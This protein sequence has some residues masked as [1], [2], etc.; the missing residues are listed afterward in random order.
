MRATGL[1]VAGGLADDAVI[2]TPEEEAKRVVLMLNTT[3]LR[4]VSGRV[5]DT[6]G[7][8]DSGDSCDSSD[9]GDS[10]DSGDSGLRDRL[11]LRS[12]RRP[13]HHLPPQAVPYPAR[14][15]QPWQ[16]PSLLGWR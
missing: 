16:D 7:S 3:L 12:S 13:H 2:I 1:E 6:L 8:G 4:K 11:P 5:S 10:C 14:P 9:S 15:H